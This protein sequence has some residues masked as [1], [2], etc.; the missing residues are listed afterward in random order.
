MILRKFWTGY[1]KGSGLEQLAGGEVADESTVGGEEV[2]VGEF[3]ELDPLEL[4]ED[5]VFEFAFK[6]SYGIELQVDSATVAVV[7]ADMRDVRADGCADAKL[8]VQFAGESLFGAFAGFD[9]ASGE[10]PLQGHWLVG[11]ALTDEDAIVATQQRCNDEAEGG[12][13]RARVGDG[14][15]VFHDSSVNAQ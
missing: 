12:S 9:F 13:R 14:L 11:T 6:G 15:R 1:D 8:F 3:F 4:V 5:F 2:V 10:F 7:V